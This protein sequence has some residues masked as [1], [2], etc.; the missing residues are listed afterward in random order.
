MYYNLTSIGLG[1][2]GWW[3]GMAGIAK[4]G[5]PWCI[6]FSMTAC[7]AALV[8]QFYRIDKLVQ[9]GDW[10]DLLDT[11]GALATVAS[12]LLIITVILNLIALLRG[13]KKGTSQDVPFCFTGTG[14]PP[15]A[16]LSGPR[17]PPH[18]KTAP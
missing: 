9:L 17:L 15:P 18:R 1:L 6:F 5:C 4:K 11:T 10:S 14:S 16:I 3:L 2:V 12:L 13:S 7:G 8:T